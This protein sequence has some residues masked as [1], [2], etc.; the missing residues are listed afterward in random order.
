M[1]RKCWPLIYKCDLHLGV[2]GLSVSHDTSYDYGEYFCRYFKI[3]WWM[4]KVKDWTFNIPSIRQYWP[5]ISKRDLDVWDRDQV[6]SHY[7]SY[8]Y[9]E[10]LCQVISN[11]L[12]P[13]DNTD[14]LSSRLVWPWP[15]R[16]G[17]G[18]FTLYVLW[19]WWTISNSLQGWKSYRLH[20]SYNTDLWSPSVTLTLGRYL[21]FF[22][23]NTSYDYSEYLWQVFKIRFK[24]C[25]VMDWTDK[26]SPFLYPSFQLWKGWGQK[27]SIC[28]QL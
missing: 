23:H 27:S 7:M 1:F 22:S 6:I 20:S 28:W 19:L 18:C 15:L 21:F 9:G 24:D 11:S 12:D 5:L 14:L 25:R 10:H 26:W 3:P 17:S 8:D 13:L 4:K 16:Q 2:R